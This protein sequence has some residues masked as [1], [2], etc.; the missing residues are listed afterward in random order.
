MIDNSDTVTEVFTSKERSYL[1]LLFAELFLGNG[2]KI[3]NLLAGEE[4]LSSPSE[5][6]HVDDLNKLIQSLQDVPERELKILYENLFLI[7]GAFYVPPYGAYYLYSKN[8]DVSTSDFIA[9][10]AKEYQAEGFL[11]YAEGM[12][13]RLDHLGI[14]FM[15]LHFLLEK[16]GD[17]VETEKK[18]R[19][20]IESKI[21]PWFGGFEK[22]VSTS[23]EYGFYLDLVRFIHQFLDMQGKKDM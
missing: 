19:S 23:L 22:K 17:M 11:D 18:I 2:K 4:I 10:I 15:Y 1:Y 20:F 7:P 14:M 13:L 9:E 8:D 3:K 5:T 21:N 16:D 6:G 12:Y